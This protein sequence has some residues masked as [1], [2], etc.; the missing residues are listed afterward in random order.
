M[1]IDLSSILAF[2]SILAIAGGTIASMVR[3]WNRVD[4]LLVKH[5]IVLDTL[6]DKVSKLEGYEQRITENENKINLINQ[7]CKFYH[8]ENDK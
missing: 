8:K 2:L 4:N 7:R 3:L 1:T 6:V 5:G